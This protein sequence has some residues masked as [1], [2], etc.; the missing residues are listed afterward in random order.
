MHT[1]GSSFINGSWATGSGS[2]FTSSNPA[3]GATVWTG[4]AA[5]EPD[6]ERAVEAARAALPGWAGQPVDARIVVVE[7]FRDAVREHADILADL[8]TAE[9]GKARWET[10]GEASSVS[11]KLISALRHIENE[12][13]PKPGQLARPPQSLVTNPTVC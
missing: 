7:R 2:I 8:I 1:D 9:T 3:T 13:G 4:K 6:I 12:P 10:A 5:T 11:A